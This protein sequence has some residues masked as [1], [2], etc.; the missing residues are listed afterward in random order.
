MQTI[1]FALWI[2]SEIKH[3]NHSIHSL[4]KWRNKLEQWDSNVMLI[5]ISSVLK[6]STWCVSLIVTSSSEL[7]E[8]SALRMTLCSLRAS[9]MKHTELFSH[10]HLCNNISTQYYNDAISLRAMTHHAICVKCWDFFITTMALPYS[11]IVCL[12]KCI[13]C[14]LALVIAGLFVNGFVVK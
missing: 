8:V 10:D 5:Y 13:L 4:N 11:K 3:A 14:L 2:N 7:Q 6:C 1:Q 9:Q 12:S